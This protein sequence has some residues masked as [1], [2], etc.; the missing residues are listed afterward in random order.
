MY[1]KIHAK[2]AFN[3]VPIAISNFLILLS[4]VDSINQCRAP[5]AT[6][7]QFQQALTLFNPL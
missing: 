5:H 7:S 1:S 2:R 6:L 3:S 4:S